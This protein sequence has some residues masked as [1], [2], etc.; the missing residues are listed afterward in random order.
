MSTWF[1]IR[2]YNLEKPF[3]LMCQLHLHNGVCP[4]SAWIKH[5]DTANKD[6]AQISDVCRCLGFLENVVSA[7]ATFARI[8]K[9][10]MKYLTALRGNKHV[11]NPLILSI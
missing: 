8:L 2:V 11:I 10:K 6:T 1:S 5:V 4:G 7:T 3:F 9:K